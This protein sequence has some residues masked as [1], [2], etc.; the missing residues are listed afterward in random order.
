MQ[1]SLLGLSSLLDKEPVVFRFDEVRDANTMDICATDRSRK[2]S[3]LCQLEPALMSIIDP[4]CFSFWTRATILL[5]TFF[6]FLSLS[7]NLNEL[8]LESHASVRI[9]LV[10]APLEAAAAGNL[11]MD[12]ASHIDDYY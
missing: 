2:N 1:P 3:R 9:T 4:I 10:F 5:C 11:G 8:F 12:D 7:T 6:Q